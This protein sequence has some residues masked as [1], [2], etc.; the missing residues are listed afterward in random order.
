MNDLKYPTLVPEHQFLKRLL[1]ALTSQ[2]HQSRLTG[3][4]HPGHS[5][6]LRLKI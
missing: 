5:H 1:I 6:M 3:R 4:S 2:M